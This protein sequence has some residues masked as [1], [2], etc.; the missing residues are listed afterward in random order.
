MAKDDE[1]TGFVDIVLDIMC[2]VAQNINDVFID[3]KSLYQIISSEKQGWSNTKI[4][5]NLQ[6]LSQRGYINIHREKNQ[7]SIRFTNKAKL[8]AVDRLAKKDDTE[9]YHF[10]SFDIPEQH[11]HNRDCFRRCLKRMGFKQ[12]Q[13]SL[14]VSNRQVGYFVEIAAEGYEVGDYIV[15]I[16]SKN[17]NINN[18]IINKFV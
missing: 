6:S 14:W 11:R 5:K 7:D 10:V 16:I 9:T 17:T 2:S 15:Y 3:R 1:K 4:S 18:T 8:R 13:K 12:I